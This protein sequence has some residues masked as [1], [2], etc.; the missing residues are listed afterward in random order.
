M[1]KLYLICALTIIWADR[2]QA[3][4]ARQLGRIAVRY[5]TQRRVFLATS[6]VAG[7]GTLCEE[8]REEPRV[9]YRDLMMRSARQGARPQGRQ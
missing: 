7:A 3:S 8:K 6:M 4:F 9:R 2:S 5:I 1:I